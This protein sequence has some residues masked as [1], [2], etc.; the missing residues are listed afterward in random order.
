M[1]ATRNPLIMIEKKNQLPESATRAEPGQERLLNDV[2][3]FSS[4]LGSLTVLRRVPF[5]NLKGAGKGLL[6]FTLNREFDY[7]R[8][9]SFNPLNSFTFNDH[10]N[11]N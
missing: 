10:L 4:S 7:E 8:N 11:F 9:K 1:A 3:Y 2:I 5:F 6:V